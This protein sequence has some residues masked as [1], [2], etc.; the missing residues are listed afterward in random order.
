MGRS[1][2]GTGEIA[3]AQRTTIINAVFFFVFWITILWAG[4]DHPPPVGFWTLIP[5]VLL[6]SALVFWRVPAYLQWME[7][8]QAGRLFR[9]AG[10]GIAAGMAFAALAILDSLLVGT[11]ES[12]ALKLLSSASS[13]ALWLVVLPAVGAGNALAIYLVNALVRRIVDGR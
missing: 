4:A 7:T 5:L 9:V 13:I 1:N 2:I 8:R 6:A 10:E 12:G 11:G 3:V